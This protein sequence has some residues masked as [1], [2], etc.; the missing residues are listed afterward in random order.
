MF[1]GTE[2]IHWICPYAC[3][4]FFL[5]NYHKMIWSRS[6]FSKKKEATEMKY[7]NAVVCCSP[8]VF[9]ARYHGVNRNNKR[10]KQTILLVVFFNTSIFLWYC[11]D[12]TFEKKIEYCILRYVERVF[13]TCITSQFTYEQS[14]RHPQHGLIKIGNSNCFIVGEGLSSAKFLIKLNFR[15]FSGLGGDG[16]RS[17]F[18]GACA[19]VPLYCLF[20]SY[21]ILICK[22]RSLQ[23]MWL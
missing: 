19:P 11:T 14:Q 9:L 3:K 10:L 2:R 4:V 8:I 21:I 15:C 1:F 22:F 18:R 20:S 7:G 5:N 6:K 23:S 16:D 13:R 12:S 17:D